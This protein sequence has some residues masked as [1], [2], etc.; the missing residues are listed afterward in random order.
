MGHMNDQS[1]LEVSV[2][3]AA[4]AVSAALCISSPGKKDHSQQQC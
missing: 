3:A 1:H 2:V 4:E